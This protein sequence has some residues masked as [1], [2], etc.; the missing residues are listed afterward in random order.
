MKSKILSFF[1]VFSILALVGLF[2]VKGQEIAPPDGGGG[3]PNGWDGYCNYN[4]APNRV[5]IYC[6]T[7]GYHCV[8]V[9]CIHG[10]C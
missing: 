5:N 1:L 4:C 9:D 6:F 10:M 3:Y 2:E 7:Q 8:Q